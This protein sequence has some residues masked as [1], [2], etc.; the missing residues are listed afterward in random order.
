MEKE[1]EQFIFLSSIAIS[2]VESWVKQKSG[3]YSHFFTAKK[4]VRHQ[5]I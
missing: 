2:V 3:F 1:L 4:W 5:M